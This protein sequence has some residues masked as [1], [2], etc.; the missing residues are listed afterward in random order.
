MVAAPRNCCKLSQACRS[1]CKC[2]GGI[3]SDKCLG[4]RGL[5]VSL[6]P[7]S[8]R[9]ASEDSSSL[10]GSQTSTGWIKAPYCLRFA[11]GE[12]VNLRRRLQINQI[13]SRIKECEA[14]RR[15]FLRLLTTGVN[16]AWI[17]ERVA[18]NERDLRVLSRQL[19]ELER[20]ELEDS[21]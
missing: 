21:A 7:W 1:R 18:E 17:S 16:L 2:H 6:G 3:E 20:L 14:D 19:R 10:A 15:W 13:N 9:R 8:A 5:L 4:R 12:C 11:E